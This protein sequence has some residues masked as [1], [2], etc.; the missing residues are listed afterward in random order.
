[1]AAAEYTLEP[2]DQLDE[3]QFRIAVRRLADSLAYGTDASPFRGTGIDYA[4][5]RRYQP[6]DSVRAIDW[7]VTART[8]KVHV[9]EY[10]APKRM[11]VYVVL[12]TSAS[13]CVGSQ[14][15]TKFALAVQLTG[16]LALAGTARM[17]PVGIVGCGARR[18][19]F[20]PTLSR[21]D[22]WR[23]LLQIRRFRFD[24]H[25]RLAEALGEIGTVARR[26]ALIVVVS[27]LHDRDA[28]PAVKQ[29]AQQHDCV[30][31]EIRDPAERGRLRSG[32]FRAEEAET[33]RAFV[34]H[35]R[36]RWLDWDAA[37]SGLRKAGVDTFRV[38]TNEP[39]TARL[40]AFLRRRDTFGR[41][42]R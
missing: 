35:G 18:L 13:M 10:E 2:H 41:G 38:V 20:P 15:P 25:T 23:Y 9:K 21:E 33:G 7:R 6:G 4:E 22:V 19:W 31:L 11:P 36:R 1:M 28:L 39:F 40:C 29:T 17:S 32:F 5:S 34:A 26:R 8:T 14:S 16:A 12:D 37:G 30:V 3:R 27:D 42:T 24:E